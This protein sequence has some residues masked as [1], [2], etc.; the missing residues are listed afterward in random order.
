MSR[1]RARWLFGFIGVALL[2]GLVWVFAPLWP[3]M[4]PVLP[5]VAAIQV[6]L[7]AWAVA[8]LV[9]DWR[10]RARDAALGAGLTETAEEASAVGQTL[11]RSVA[12]LRRS[13]RRHVLTELP[14]YAIIGP[15]GAG[16]T[17]ALL[18]AGLSFTLPDQ[19]GHAAI[20]G[21]GGT[22]LC[23]W[24]FTDQAVLIDTA[25]RYTTQDSDAE[26]D[27][28]GWNAFLSLLKRT[29]PLQPL[30]GVIVAIGLP[31]VMQATEAERAAH[32]AAI[33]RRIAELETRFALRLPVYALF[34][35]ADL[36]AGFSETF[37]GLDADARAQVWG[38]TFPLSAPALHERV[39]ASLRGLAKTLAQRMLPTIAAEPR[40]DRWPAIAGFPTQFASLERP[41]AAFVA[42]AFAGAPLL[43]GV[44]FA[45][46][47][48]E[49]TPMDRLT[50][51][52]SR[53]FGLPATR[54]AALSPQAG[55]AYF[56]HD[57]LHRVIFNEALLVRDPRGAAAGRLP[58]GSRWRGVGRIAGFAVLLLA[59]AAAAAGLNWSAEQA[60]AQLDAPAAALAALRPGRPP[61][62]GKPA[63]GRRPAL[64]APRAGP[65]GSPAGQR[66]GHP[67]PARPGPGREAQGR[68]PRHLPRRSG[69]RPAA[70]PRGAHGSR[71]ARRAV[72]PDP[73]VRGH[74][75]RPDARRR[76]AARPGAGARLHGPRLEPELFR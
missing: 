51:A 19:L 76:R 43:R 37:E 14:W 23:E 58:D 12:L 32:A 21:A 57:L 33:A 20:A 30:N 27:R 44:Y 68:G 48:Q 72:P 35:K 67:G 40:A 71:H 59:L 38:E 4:E 60:R 65:G 6:L 61:P 50:G 16:K 11:S 1:S 7:V 47:T 54:P 31:D 22:R 56:L 66:A 5:R 53:A 62:G 3:V 63:A 28:A 75:D 24:W 8:N 39:A 69:L 55:R 26:V 18:N 10:S 45:S 34:T 64:A 15:P 36:V 42:A 52:M 29:R 73:V 17:T 41:L 46:G 2:A 13:G 70:P 49:G 74:P 25:G 9:L